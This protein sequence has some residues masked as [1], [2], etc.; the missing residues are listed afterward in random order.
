MKHS[1][2]K[3]SVIQLVPALA[4]LLAGCEMHFTL[5]QQFSAPTSQSEFDQQTGYQLP[6]AIHLPNSYTGW[7]PN[8]LNQF[9]YDASSQSY[10]VNNIELNNKQ[11]DS[12]GSRFKIAN[13]DWTHEF[14]FSK[15]HDTPEQSKF[16]IS[17]AGSIVHLQH[18]FYASDMYFELPHNTKARYLHARF[19]VL[20][21]SATPTALLS[22]TLSAEK[23]ALTH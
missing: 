22:V 20:E 18:I 9:V 4:L 16:G 10:Y 23:K 5:P 6:Y 12:W 8:E 7:Q 15:A 14:G 19:K 1:R 3:L 11:V 17:E 21:N 13:A 2:R